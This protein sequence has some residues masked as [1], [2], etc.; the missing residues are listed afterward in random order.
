M[1][2]AIAGLSTLAAGL[3]VPAVLRR[4]PANAVSEAEAAGLQIEDRLEIEGRT[5][6]SAL[7]HYPSYRPA[8]PAVSSEDGSEAVITEPTATAPDTSVPRAIA[9]HQTAAPTFDTD[10]TA[11]GMLLDCVA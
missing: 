7:P 2:E 11:P 1:L 5:S 6:A 4:P 8:A 3:G 9:G 10:A